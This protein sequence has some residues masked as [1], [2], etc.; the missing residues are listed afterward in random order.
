MRRLNLEYVAI[1]F[2]IVQLLISNLLIYKKGKAMPVTG[3]GGP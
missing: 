3:R 2:K 1:Y